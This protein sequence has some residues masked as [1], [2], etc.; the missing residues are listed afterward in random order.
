MIPFLKA[1]VT[2]DMLRIYPDNKRVREL[3]FSPDTPEDTVRKCRERLQG[4][5]WRACMEMR[6]PI[7]PPL[8][9]RC[10]TLV[11]GGALDQLVPVE[12]TIDTAQAYQAETKIFLG[13]GHNLM[14]EQC[15]KDVAESIDKWIKLRILHLKIA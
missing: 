3:L 2:R 8:K 9:V 5:S 12:S 11:L 15:W 14:L 4:E 10:P 7:S 13:S 6:D 1:A